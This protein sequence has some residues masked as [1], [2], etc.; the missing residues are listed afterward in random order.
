MFEIFQMKQTLFQDY[1]ASRGLTWKNMLNESLLALQRGVFMLSG[2]LCSLLSTYNCVCVCEQSRGLMFCMY[3]A[4]DIMTSSLN[5]ISYSLHWHLVQTV[6][7]SRLQ[8]YWEH[9]AL[10]LLWPP[11]LSRTCLPVQAKYS[12]CWTARWG[13]L[14]TVQRKSV[15]KLITFGSSIWSLSFKWDMGCGLLWQI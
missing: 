3:I 2:A 7:F 9:S 5:Q 13:S 14:C 1:L 10:L 4:C 12:C 6:L 15:K 11:Q 8:N